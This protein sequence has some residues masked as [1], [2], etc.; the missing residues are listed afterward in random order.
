M[1]ERQ[2]IALCIIIAVVGIGT[3]AAMWGYLIWA[4]CQ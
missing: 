2:Y 1:T 3:G 4:M